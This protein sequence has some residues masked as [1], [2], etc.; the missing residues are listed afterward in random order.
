MPH[1][2][3][4]KAVRNQHRNEDGDFAKAPAAVDEEAVWETFDEVDADIEISEQEERIM[5]EVEDCDDVLTALSS[6][7]TEVNQLRWTK[8]ASQ[9][10]KEL[11]AFRG[12]SVRAGQRKKEKDKK[13]KEAAKS[14]R[15]I[16]SYFGDHG[17]ERTVRADTDLEEMQKIELAIE[18]LNSDG[19]ASQLKNATVEKSN[20]KITKWEYVQY[21]SILRYFQARYRKQSDGNHLG[22][23]EASVDVAK[24]IF[25][26]PGEMSYKARCIR[27]WADFYLENSFLPVHQQGKHAKAFSIIHDEQACEILKEHIRSIPEAQRTPQEF[28]RR[29]NTDILRGLNGGAPESVNEVT[30][31][32]WMRYLGF[33]RV[34]GAKGF[35][36]DGSNAIC[37]NNA[38][39][40]SLI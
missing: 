7:L 1:N 13:I 27:K 25:N 29:L 22:K 26:K 23:M 36:T 37:D 31:T 11:P 21:L 34:P 39:S 8:E 3:R 14:T 17:E 18:K 12:Q 9:R 38:L 33:D 10:E 35:Y 30:A 24:I 4:Q 6:V 20:R 28:M 19:L 32:I 15:K 16:T 2:R 5:D 40:H